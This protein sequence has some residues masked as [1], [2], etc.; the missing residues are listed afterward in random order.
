MCDFLRPYCLCGYPR[1][2]YPIVAPEL[3]MAE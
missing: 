3:F 1:Y 2:I